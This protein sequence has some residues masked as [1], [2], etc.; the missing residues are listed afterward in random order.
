MPRHTHKD[1]ALQLDRVHQIERKIALECRW[2]LEADRDDRGQHI[3]TAHQAG[4]LTRIRDLTR[5][6]L[7][8]RSRF[9][10]MVGGSPGQCSVCGGPLAGDHAC[11]N[12]AC[13]GSGG[14]GTD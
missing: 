10:V 11:A 1:L 5:Q 4:L 9:D 6:W 13:T 14:S 12:P 2:L 8:A 3:V 7:R